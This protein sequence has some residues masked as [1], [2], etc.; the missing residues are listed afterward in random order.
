MT[1]W[2]RDLGKAV[3]EATRWCPRSSLLPF[4][5]PACPHPPA[6]SPGSPQTPHSW[7]WAPTAMQNIPSHDCLLLPGLVLLA[8]LT[9]LSH[10]PGAT[11]TCEEMG[12]RQFPLLCIHEVWRSTFIRYQ[13]LGKGLPSWG[14]G[15]WLLTPSL[16]QTGIW[17]AK[18]ARWS[19]NWLLG[20]ATTFFH[21]L[22]TASYLGFG[23]IYCVSMVKKSFAAYAAPLLCCV[24]KLMK[25][26]ILLFLCF[27]ILWWSRFAMHSEV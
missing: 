26:Q 19:Q 14:T 1:L 23:K 11:S 21:R 20:A 18:L 7:G 22:E 6:S 12:T 10:G 17:N 15:E 25:A 5:S 2:D 16:G 9:A 3:S 24:R 8:P 27:G 13:C 4:L